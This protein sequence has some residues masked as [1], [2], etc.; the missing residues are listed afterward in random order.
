[1]LR[2]NDAPMSSTASPIKVVRAPAQAHAPAT[3]AAVAARGAATP[4]ANGWRPAVSDTWQWQLT[5]TINTTYDVAV[6]DIDLFDTPD[7]TLQSLHAQG[8]KIVCYFSAGSSEDWRPDFDQFK[9][10]DMGKPLDG[11]KGERWL[12]IRS[13]NVRRIMAARLDLAATRG[14]DGV[15]PDNVDGYANKNGLN[16]TS[17]DQLDYNRYIADQAHQRGLAVALKNDL[18]Q[19]AALEPAFDFAVNEQCNQYRECD[20]LKPFTTAGKAI[21][22]AE[23]AAKYKK[24]GGQATL[25]AASRAASIRTLV[26]AKKLNDS[27]R[28]SCD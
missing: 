21:F 27:Y 11:W 4:K 23:Y 6:Y 5:G 14:C 28:Y 20:K 1:V 17:D 24:A 26:L 19:V 22:N 8:R 10:S 7:A 9:P 2:R 13:A 3:S 18:D 16:L 12:D 25:C 15:E